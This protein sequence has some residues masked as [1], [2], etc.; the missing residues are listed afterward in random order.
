MRISGRARKYSQ[1]GHKNFHKNFQGRNGSSMIRKL[2][3][4]LFGF[5]TYSNFIILFL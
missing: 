2:A 1:K 5:A 4:G 3:C